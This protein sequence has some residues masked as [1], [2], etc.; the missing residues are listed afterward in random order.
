MAIEET[1]YPICVRPQLY[2][3]LSEIFSADKLLE[4]CRR[5]NI[6]VLDQVQSPGHFLRSLS[7]QQIYKLPHWTFAVCFLIKNYRFT[8]INML[9]CALTYVKRANKPSRIRSKHVIAY[10]VPAHA[11][12]TG[13]LQTQRKGYLSFIFHA[14]DPST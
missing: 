14:T 2:P 7:Q 1:E 12:T 8:H 11:I 10:S 3:A 13:I 6:E 9:T 4:I 5:H